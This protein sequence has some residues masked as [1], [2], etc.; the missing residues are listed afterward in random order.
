MGR[1]FA[2]H[3]QYGCLSTAGA[4]PNPR[5]LQPLLNAGY[6]VYCGFDADPTGD[7]MA[8]ALIVLHPTGRRL[9]PSAY[10][11]FRVPGAGQSQ[12]K[13]LQQTG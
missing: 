3:P 8:G 5:W 1:C 10:D 11:C 2:L 9:R 7:Q 12:R 6:Q 4:R 13:D